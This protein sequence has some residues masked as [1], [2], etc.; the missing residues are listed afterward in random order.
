[1]GVINPQQMIPGHGY[2]L[3][4]NVSL[5]VSRYYIIMALFVT[6]GLGMGSP[7]ERRYYYANCPAIG[8]HW[9]D[10]IQ[11]HPKVSAPNNVCQKEEDYFP[12]HIMFK[13]RS[14]VLNPQ[15]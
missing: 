9:L 15:T 4:T 7:S 8:I 2:L 3:C 6:M 1:M 11:E 12:H 10:D 13:K 14:V 5:T